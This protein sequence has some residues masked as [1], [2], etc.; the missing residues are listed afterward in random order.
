[1]NR[2]PLF[3][4]ILHDGLRTISAEQARSVQW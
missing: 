4:Q 2:V 3:A 1:V